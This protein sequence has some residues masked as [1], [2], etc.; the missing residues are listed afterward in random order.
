[1]AK[2]ETGKR[3]KKKKKLDNST[4][5]MALGIVGGGMVLVLA[6]ALPLTIYFASKSWGDGETKVKEPELSNLEVQKRETTALEQGLNNIG[7]W[8]WDSLANRPT[9]V[10][11]NQN[12]AKVV[13]SWGPSLPKK[14][15]F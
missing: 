11:V 5:Y 12:G 2:V 14:N 13:N 3:P 7:G 4:K 6:I 15:S 10:D 9:G 8:N 1:M